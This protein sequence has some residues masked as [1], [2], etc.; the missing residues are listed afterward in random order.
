[1]PELP[2]KL[3]ANEQEFLAEVCATLSSLLY[4]SNTKGD[5]PNETLQNASEKMLDSA[6]RYRF[7]PQTLSSMYDRLHRTGANS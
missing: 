4:I 1:M 2:L 5:L 6:D 3:T 7:T